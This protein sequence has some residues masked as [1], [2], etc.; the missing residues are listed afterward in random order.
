MGINRTENNYNDAKEFYYSSKVE[1]LGDLSV[2]FGYEDFDLSGYELH[3]GNTYPKEFSSMNDIKKLD[4]TKLYKQ[5]YT[6]VLLKSK[7]DGK[8]FTN[9]PINIKLK[10]E[11][12]NNSD[13]KLLNSKSQ[14]H[15]KEKW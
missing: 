7:S 8:P 1:D 9:L 6:S 2:F 15:H 5:G 3:Q 13:K 14:L 12:K 4:F 11:K 10:N